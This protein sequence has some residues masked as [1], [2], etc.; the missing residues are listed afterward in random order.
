MSATYHHGDLRRAIID[1]AIEKLR[2]DSSKEL[3]LRDLAKAI[4]VSSAAPYRHFSDKAELERCIAEEGFAKFVEAMK[5]AIAGVPPSEQVAELVSC[6]FSFEQQHPGHY[7]LMFQSPASRAHQG[8]GVGPA[9]EALDI[10]GAA[11]RRAGSLSDDGEVRS[12]AILLCASLH[13]LVV[14]N[15]SGPFTRLPFGELEQ[16]G[17]IASQ[18]LMER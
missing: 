17:L 7:N 4:G 16:L 12:S 9:Y 10:L 3:S 8:D 6:Y 18:R 13:G 2:E 15:R 1:A 14:L 11:I 5:Q